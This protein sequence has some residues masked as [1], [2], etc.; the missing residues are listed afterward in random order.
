M[1][2]NDIPAITNANSNPLRGWRASKTVVWDVHIS[3]SPRIHSRQ[4]QAVGQGSGQPSC[5]FFIR[6]FNRVFASRRAVSPTEGLISVWHRSWTQC[7]FIRWLPGT[8]RVKG[9]TASRPPMWPFLSVQMSVPIW[10][11]RV[12]FSPKG[13]ETGECSCLIAIA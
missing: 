7:H 10:R 13:Q 4:P 5:T 3:I 9:H 12:C 8:A 1:D 2:T 11:D 6:C